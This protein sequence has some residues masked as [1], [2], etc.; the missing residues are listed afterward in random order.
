[1]SRVN[2]TRPIKIPD[3]YRKPWTAND[4]WSRF[5]ENS[6]RRQLEEEKVKSLV[7]SGFMDTEESEI[8]ILPED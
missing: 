5:L 2:H 7:E 4:H 3:I 8:I 6:T 1:M